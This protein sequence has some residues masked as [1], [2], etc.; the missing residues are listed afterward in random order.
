MIAHSEHEIIN[1]TKLHSLDVIQLIVSRAASASGLARSVAPERMLD[2]IPAREPINHLVT[3]I[4]IKRKI[5]I[6]QRKRACHAPESCDLNK[7][8]S[9]DVY[10]HL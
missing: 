4:G 5:R 9:R 2:S 6:N 3:G 1:Y 7:F 10:L 8:I